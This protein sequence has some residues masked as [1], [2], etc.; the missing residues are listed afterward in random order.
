MHKINFLL[1]Y[2]I[3]INIYGMR[4]V[5]C[6]P[7]FAIPISTFNISFWR[8]PYSRLSLKRLIYKKIKF[9][10]EVLL[11]TSYFNLVIRYPLQ[12][13]YDTNVFGQPTR[14]LYFDGNVEQPAKLFFS[15]FAKSFLTCACTH[16]RSPVFRANDWRDPNMVTM[17]Y[18]RLAVNLIHVFT[19]YLVVIVNVHVL[20]VGYAIAVLLFCLRSFSRFHFEDG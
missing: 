18:C 3:L 6:I 13:L 4:D 14:F 16:W 9:S 2:T 11:K 10:H 19:H 15:L 8:G 1:C 20:S 5:V 17:A 12:P 7:F